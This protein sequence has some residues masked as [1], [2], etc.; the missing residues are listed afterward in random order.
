MT[1][2]PSSSSATT[3]ES[4]A[5]ADSQAVTHPILFFDGVCGLC[6]HF[7]DFVI[8]WDRKAKIRFAPLQGETAAARFSSIPSEAL[9]TVIF[10]VD[11]REFRQSSAVVRVFWKLG[12]I[13]WVLGGL[14]W[15]VPKPLRDLG[16]RIVAANRYRMFGRKEACRLPTPEERV[17]FLP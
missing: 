1:A 8:R 11:G 17:R 13:W 7:V 16:Y 15:S 2:Q 12:G 10:V 9:K 6:S 5:T 3:S 4:T 14:L